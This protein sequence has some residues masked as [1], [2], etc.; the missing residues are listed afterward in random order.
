MAKLGFDY[1]A[2]YENT[3]KQGGGGILPHMYGLI[4]AE[5][6]TPSKTKDE[7][8]YQVEITFEVQEPVEFKGR[9]FWAYWTVVHSDEWNHGAYKY[10]KPM[11]DRFGRAVGIEITGDTDTDELTYKTFVAEIGIQQG[12]LKNDGSGDFY[13]DKNQI[14]RFYY[15]DENAKEPIPEL[16]VIGDGTQGKAPRASPPAAN[17]NRPAANN[18]RPSAAPAVA[19]AKAAGSRPWGV[20]K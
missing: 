20:K 5:S 9:K 11:F 3:E 1:Q 12:N 4:W 18:N 6:I 17:N 14:E 7:K 16:G 19:P 15:S 13:K 8:G 10:G 2:D